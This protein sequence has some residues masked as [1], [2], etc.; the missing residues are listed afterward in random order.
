MGHDHNARTHLGGRRQRNHASGDDVSC[1]LAL[2]KGTVDV[3]SVLPSCNH[4]RATSM[5]LLVCA[6]LALQRAECHLTQAGV[7]KPYCP[8]AELGD[9]V[10]SLGGPD[11]VRGHHGVDAL[12]DA[13]PPQL[14]GNAP[15][16]FTTHVVQRN[17]QLPLH[18]PLSIP[19][20]FP[21][22]HDEQLRPS[23]G[24]LWLGS[25]RGGSSRATLSC[26]ADP[27]ASAAG[28]AAAAA[29]GSSASGGR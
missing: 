4:L 14:L 29:A 17:V 25:A 6:Q 13:Q 26:A 11:E 18:S 15:G 27:S 8:G 21:M 22:P 20:R 24:R 16:L 10:G 28:A 12:R 23:L 1:A 19:D 3:R 5:H 2:R 7:L 9:G